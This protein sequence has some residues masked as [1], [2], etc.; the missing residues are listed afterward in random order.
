MFRLARRGSAGLIGQQNIGCVVNRNRGGDF[1]RSDSS[2]KRGHEIQLAERQLFRTLGCGKTLHNLQFK[3]PVI[4][5]S[6]E[7]IVLVT[8]LFPAEHEVAGHV[9][10]H[11]DRQPYPFGEFGLPLFAAGGKDQ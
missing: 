3:P 8:V 9:V 10:V 7:Q 1:R 6:L 2:R 4:G 5:I 11:S